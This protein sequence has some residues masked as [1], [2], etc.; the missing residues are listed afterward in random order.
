MLKAIVIFFDKLEDKVRIRLSHRSILYAF[1]GGTGTVLFWRGMWHTADILMQK[2]GFWG[3]V[4]YEP[5]TVIWASIILLMTGL[6]VSNFIGERIIISGIKKEKKVTDK[7]EAEVDKEEDEIRSIRT[8]I[9]Q[10]SKNVEEIKN[11]I[12]KK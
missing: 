12:S 9:N 7:T 1:V 3:W 4:F 5:N 11:S 2:G 6:F 10:I 8:K